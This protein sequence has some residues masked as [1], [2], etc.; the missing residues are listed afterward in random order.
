M[1]T[2]HQSA[3][4][5]M[6]LKIIDGGSSSGYESSRVMLDEPLSFWSLCVELVDTSSQAGLCGASL[7]GTVALSTSITTASGRKLQ[8]AMARLYP[9]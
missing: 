2:I 3:G 7:Y 6:G 5:G 4:S 9:R 8:A 1:T